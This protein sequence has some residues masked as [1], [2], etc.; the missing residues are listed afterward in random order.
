MKWY[1]FQCD[2]SVNISQPLVQLSLFGNWTWVY[3]IFHW[4]SLAPVR[5]VKPSTVWMCL[6]LPLMV[7]VQS[8]CQ[9]F[10]TK[11]HTDLSS[12][13][14][15]FSLCSISFYGHVGTEYRSSVNIKINIHIHALIQYCQICKSSINT[16][17]LGQGYVCCKSSIK[18][19]WMLKQCENL[20]ELILFHRKVKLS[21]SWSVRHFRVNVC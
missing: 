5:A 17:T 21:G 14:N 18:M 19:L 8:F 13:A 3:L 20:Y 4:T 9:K 1:T 2:F 15:L 7:F 12:L 6:G 11:V 16:L 10:C